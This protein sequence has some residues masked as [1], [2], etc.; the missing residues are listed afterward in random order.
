MCTVV[1]INICV[2]LYSVL[3]CSAVQSGTAGLF[4][5]LYRDGDETIF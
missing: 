5:V 4:C 1:I 3:Y 2:G